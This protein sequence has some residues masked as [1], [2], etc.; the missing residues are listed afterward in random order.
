MRKCVKENYDVYV[1]EPFR[2]GIYD[3]LLNPSDQHNHINPNVDEYYNN[4][5]DLLL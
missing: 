3:Y 4:F 2:A 5:L 1:M